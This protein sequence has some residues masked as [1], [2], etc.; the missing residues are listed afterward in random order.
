MLIAQLDVPVRQINEVR[1]EIVLRSVK[2][3]LSK[4]PPL[5]PLR[6]PYQAHVRITRQAVALRRIAG[7]ETKL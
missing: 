1:L 4:R 7:H 5:R 3:D 6:F 2:R